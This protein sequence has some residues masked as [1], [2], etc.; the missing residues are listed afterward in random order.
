M[1][2]FGCT[3]KL[4]EKK[5]KKLGMM[6]DM[7]FNYQS[8]DPFLYNMSKSETSANADDGKTHTREDKKKTTQL[9]AN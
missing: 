7:G 2:H 1:L 6:G 4:E 9:S 3:G 5:K 8:C